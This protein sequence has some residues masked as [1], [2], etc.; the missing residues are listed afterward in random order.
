MTAAAA[1]AA[2]ALQARGMI[3]TTKSLKRWVGWWVPYL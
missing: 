2:A 1:A 3:P